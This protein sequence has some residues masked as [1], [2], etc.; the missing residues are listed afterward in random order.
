MTKRINTSIF[1]T[2]AGVAV[3]TLASVWVWSGATSTA[4]AA[5]GGIFESLDRIAV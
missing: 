2:L 4:N 1:V 3:M 5:P